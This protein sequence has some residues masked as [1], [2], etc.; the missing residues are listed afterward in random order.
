MARLAEDPLEVREAVD[1]PGGIGS[2]ASYWTVPLPATGTWNTPGK[3]VAQADIV[4]TA[5]QDRVPL[6]FIEVDN[7]DETPKELADNLEG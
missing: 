2:I 4:L 3:G 7:C 6:L 1:A 5:S